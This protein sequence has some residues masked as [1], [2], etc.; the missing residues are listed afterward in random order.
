MRYSLA[1]L[2][3][4][5]ILTGRLSAQSPSSHVYFGGGFETSGVGAGYERTIGRSLQA[6]LVRQYR[7]LGVRFGATYFFG[8]AYFQG[9]LNMTSYARPRAIGATLELAY[10]IGSHRLRPY[11]I[12]GWGLYRFSGVLLTPGM[13][14]TFDQISP[15]MIGGLGIRYRIGARQ[16]FIEARAHGFTNGPDWGPQLMPVTVGLRF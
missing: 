9:G 2:L 11:I 16:L 3:V 7:S 13:S 6:G 15:A 12:G 14:E 1:T 10:D 5:G 4:L 8:A